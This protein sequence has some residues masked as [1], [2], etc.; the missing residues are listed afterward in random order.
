[1]EVP[2]VVVVVEADQCEVVVE[3]RR[4][5]LGRDGAELQELNEVVE[6]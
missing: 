5:L 1:V 4:V 2:E 3:E 6:L